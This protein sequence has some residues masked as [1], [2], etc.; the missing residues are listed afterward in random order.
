M[1]QTLDSLS[2]SQV[3]LETGLTTHT[4]RYYE[5]AGLMLHPVDRASSSHRRFTARDVTWVVFLTKLRLTGMPISVMRHYVEL[6]RSGDSSNAER[7]QLLQQHRL[8][9]IAQLDDITQSLSAIDIKIA[10]YENSL[11]THPSPSERER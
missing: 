2:I 11:L 9:V 3:A 5:R 1:T 10:L 4:L 8:S 7:L 6:A